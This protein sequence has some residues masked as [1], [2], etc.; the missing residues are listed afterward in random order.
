MSDFKLAHVDSMPDF[1]SGFKYHVAVTVGDSG[2]YSWTGDSVV[3]GPECVT[4]GEW[5][6]TIDRLIKSLEQVRREGLRK[7]ASNNRGQPSTC[8][9]DVGRH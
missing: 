6:V 5:N 7:L 4:P 8:A 3:L 1:E 2:G 9:P